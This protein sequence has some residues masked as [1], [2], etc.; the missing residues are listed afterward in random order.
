MGTSHRHPMKVLHTQWV[1]NTHPALL[2]RKGM[3]TGVALRQCVQQCLRLLQVSGV[4]ALGEPAV[5]WRTTVSPL[6]SRF[7]DSATGCSTPWA[8][9]NRWRQHP[10]CPA[11]SPLTTRVYSGSPKGWLAQSISASNIAPAGTCRSRRR[12]AAPVLRPRRNVPTPQLK[13]QKQGRRA[14]DILTEFHPC[15]DG[16]G[17][18][19]SIDIIG[20]LKELNTGGT[21]VLVSHHRIS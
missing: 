2:G 14:L 19:P 16:H 5:G 7:V 8:L 11:S 6:A 9:R 17:L 10:S 13:G 20:V 21:V 3:S 1:M 18:V 15:S 4:K 12:R